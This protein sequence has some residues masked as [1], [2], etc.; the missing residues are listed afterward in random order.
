MLTSVQEGNP[1][2]LP[3][4]SESFLSWYIIHTVSRHEVKVADGLTMKNLEVFLPRVMVRSRRRDRFQMLEMPLFP[5]YLFVHT[6]LRFSDYYRIIRQDGVLRILGI[7][8]HFTPMPEETVASIRKLV[9]SGLSISPWAQLEPGKSVRVLD[10]PLAGAVGIIL[11]VKKGN[12]RLVVG[13]ELLGQSI[14]ADLDRE[15]VEP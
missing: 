2:S 13:V 4:Q 15:T 8:G 3:A 10:G 7:K 11:R 12:R 9:K 6:D 5:G 1:L 14:C